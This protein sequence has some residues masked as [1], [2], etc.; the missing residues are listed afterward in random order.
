MVENDNDIY[1]YVKTKYPQLFDGYMVSF[2]CG[3]GWRSLI[4]KICER[5]KDSKAK[6]R[7]AKEK[8]GG[9]RFY[10]DFANEEDENFI[11]GVEQ[12]SLTVCENCGTRVNVTTKGSW[13]KTVCSDCR[14]SDRR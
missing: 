7:Q 6:I 3:R 4:I 9:L 8:F 5:I 11:N 13:I 1:E 10:T 12:E 14:D 2:D